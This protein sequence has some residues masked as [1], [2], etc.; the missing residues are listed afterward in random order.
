MVATP[1]LRSVVVSNVAGNVTSSNERSALHAANAYGVRPGIVMLSSTP[2]AC[3][4]PSAS[5]VTLPANTK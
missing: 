2:M 4:A 1:Y 3:D 5:T